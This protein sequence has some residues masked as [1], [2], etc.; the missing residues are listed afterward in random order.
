MPYVLVRHK[1][2]DFAKWKPV[3]D[4]HGAA[5][6]A[7]GSKGA[8]LFR[9]IDK[10]KETVILLEWSDIGQARSFAKSK[11]LREAMKRAGVT[12]KP[13]IYFL[14]EVEQAPA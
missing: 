2:K 10:P 5:R 4:A 7:G 12:D 14:D 11:D 9:N 8:R 1:V 13:D 3:Y 6:K